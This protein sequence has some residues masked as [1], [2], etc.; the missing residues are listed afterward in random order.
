M[1]ITLGQLTVKN[2]LGLVLGFKLYLRLYVEK[3]YA[4]TILLLMLEKAN[5][6]GQGGVNG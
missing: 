2:I 4:Q 5:F 1:V 3:L 6:L